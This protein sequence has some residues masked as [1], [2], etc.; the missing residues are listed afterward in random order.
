LLSLFFSSVF[1]RTLN[2]SK[3]YSYSYYNY[4]YYNMNILLRSFFSLSLVYKQKT[5]TRR[6]IVCVCACVLSFFSVLFRLFS[7]KDFS[8]LLLFLLLFT[9]WS[10]CALSCSY[11]FFFCFLGFC[12]SFVKAQNY[13]SFLVIHIHQVLCCRRCCCCYFWFPFSFSFF[14]SNINN[15]RMKKI[16][17]ILSIEC[18]PTQCV[19]RSRFLI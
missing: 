10:F 11:F 16:T 14:V 8:F 9:W 18:I 5:I 7:S 15:N 19:H 6:F 4:H 13:L 12:F 17:N 1:L 2:K 3:Y